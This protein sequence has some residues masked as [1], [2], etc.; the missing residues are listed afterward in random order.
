MSASQSKT[1]VASSTPQ[2]CPSIGN[3]RRRSNGLHRRSGPRSRLV[4]ALSPATYSS[5]LRQ[6]AGNFTR[7]LRL[8]SITSAKQ[9]GY[10]VLT[11]VAPEAPNPVRVKDREEE[12]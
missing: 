5:H 7:S 2:T 6:M 9:I 8:W 11:C 3:R 12:E 4:A 10:N 1:P